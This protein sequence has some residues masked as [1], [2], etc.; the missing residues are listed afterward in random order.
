[1]SED[2]SRVKLKGEANYLEWLKRFQGTARVKKWGTYTCDVFNAITE[3]ELEALV[4]IQ[5]RAK[6]LIL[7]TPSIYLKSFSTSAL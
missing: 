7:P 3:K 2:N 4:S 1:M 5:K 6:T